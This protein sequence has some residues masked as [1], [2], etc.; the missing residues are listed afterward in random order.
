M[1]HVRRL[2][3]APLPAFA[4]TGFIFMSNPILPVGFF[5]DKVPDKDRHQAELFA[6]RLN[7]LARHL[8]RWPGK[9]GISCFRLYERDIPEIPF[10]VDRYA[11]CLHIT[12][13][14]RPH[15]RDPDHH[16]RWLELMTR[17]ASTILEV[18][19]VNV[20]FKSRI[21]QASSQYEKL[22]DT[23]AVRIVQEAGLGFLVNL[24]DYVDTGLFLDHRITRGM[25]R[26]EAEGKSFLN[27]FAYT[28]SF[29]VYAAAG[30]A[31]STTTV[32]WSNTYL[33]WARQNMSHNGY[34]GDAHQFVREDA[35]TFLRASGDKYDLVVVDPPTHSNRKDAVDWMVQ[36]QHG[37]LL[38]RLATRVNPSGVVYFS[39]NYR[40]FKLDESLIEADFAIRE[41]S[42][43]TVPE[44][45]R[46]R[47]IHRCWRLIRR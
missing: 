2:P 18:E 9:R 43:Q 46:N 16:S 45:F 36:Q 20:F 17:T 6:Q 44:D 24:S 34:G 3:P 15:V 21:R 32:D 31:L 5:S 29:S 22:S 1:H 23:G 41:I 7:K 27:L 28:G 39:T 10:V 47:R 38:H 30:G 35:M 40:R 12:E 8:R 19:P 4:A 11:D 13:Y 42:R 33:N 14:E 26:R 37:E 25:V